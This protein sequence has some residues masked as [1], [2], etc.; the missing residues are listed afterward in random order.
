MLQPALIGG[1]VNGV[2]SGLPVINIGNICC[3]LWVIVGGAVAAYMLQQKREVPI[4]AGDGAAVGHHREGHSRR[5]H[6]RR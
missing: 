4:N 3:C 1:V 5:G 2:L 6:D